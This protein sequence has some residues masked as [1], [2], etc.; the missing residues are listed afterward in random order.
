MHDILYKN[1]KKVMIVLS[2]WSCKKKVNAIFKYKIWIYCY[3][4]RGRKWCIHSYSWRVDDE[5]NVFAWTI[6]ESKN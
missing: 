3:T 2:E 1:Y 5:L 4:D 6:N